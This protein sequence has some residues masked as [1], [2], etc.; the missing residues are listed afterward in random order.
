MKGEEEEEEEE[1]KEE[2]EEEEEV[3]RRQLKR[4]HHI[5]HMLSF[6]RCASPSP[7]PSPSALPTLP[8]LL[9]LSLIQS[10]LSTPSL[11]SPLHFFPPPTMIYIFFSNA[12]P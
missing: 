7:S 5:H 3:S 8:S 6:S 9:L 11:T 10:I 1:E 2:E 12:R 4:R